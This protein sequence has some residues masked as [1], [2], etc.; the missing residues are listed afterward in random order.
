MQVQPQVQPLVQP[1]GQA[2]AQLEQALL[3]RANDGKVTVDQFKDA[4]RSVE[5]DLSD[6]ELKELLRDVSIDGNGLIDYRIGLT[7]LPF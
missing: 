7:E 5:N 2:N 6:E 1:Q 4:L 3:N